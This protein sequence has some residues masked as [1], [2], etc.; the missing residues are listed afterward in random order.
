MCYA[1]ADANLSAS[2][3]CLRLLAC[4]SS[5]SSML[6]ILCRVSSV[7]VCRR[8]VSSVFVVVVHDEE[9]DVKYVRRVESHV[10]RVILYILHVHKSYRLFHSRTFLRPCENDRVCDIYRGQIKEGW[11]V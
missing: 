9:V 8:C 3:S 5:S 6:G 7:F 4:P 2:L 11:N 1:R 10:V